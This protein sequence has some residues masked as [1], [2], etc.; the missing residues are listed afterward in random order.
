MRFQ[1]LPSSVPDRDRDCHGCVFVAGRNESSGDARFRA[2]QENGRHF[3]QALAASQRVLKV[4]LTH[5][6]PK[7]M[8]LPDRIPGGALA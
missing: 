8:L 3:E 5:A 7:T 6:D 1:Q 4:W 2:A